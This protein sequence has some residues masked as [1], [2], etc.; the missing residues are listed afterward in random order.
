MFY[1]RFTRLLHLLIAT[2]IVLELVLSLVMVHPKPGRLGDT[3]YALHATWGQVL[4]GLLVV[5][6]IWRIVGSGQVSVALLFPWFSLERCQAVVADMQR[7]MAHAIRFRL[8]DSR[9]VSPLASAVQGLG[10]CVATLLGM[11]GV[12]LVLGME[13]DG[14]MRGWVHAVKE[15]HEVLGSLLWGYLVVHASMAVLHQWAGEGRLGAMVRVWE[16]MP[17]PATASHA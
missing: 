8:P 11:S 10:L 14:A 5:H 7:Y 15:G 4:L 1:D 13:A 16:K 9:Q 2:G 6:W 12:L 17:P 3:F